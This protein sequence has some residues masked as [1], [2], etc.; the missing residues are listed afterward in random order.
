LPP[1][2][3]GVGADWIRDDR[4]AGLQDAWFRIEITLP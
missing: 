3:A 4:P 1:E 2:F